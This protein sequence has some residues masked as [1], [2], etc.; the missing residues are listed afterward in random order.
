MFL[1][2]NQYTVF[3]QKDF[4][5]DLIHIFSNVPNLPLHM[6]RKYNS[7]RLA[8]FIFS[9]YGYMHYY[10]Y[11]II[12][13]LRMASRWLLPFYIYLISYNFS[14]NLINFLLVNF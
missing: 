4:P 8:R 5:F 13:I 11:G 12:Y 1:P 3:G 2:S 6:S 7:N 9:L 14:F 10:L